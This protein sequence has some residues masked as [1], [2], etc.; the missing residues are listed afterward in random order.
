MLLTKVVD[1]AFLDRE[2]RQASRPTFSTPPI[3]NKVGFK[4]SWDMPI[5]P[6]ESAYAAAE[7]CVVGFRAK[8]TKRRGTQKLD[9]YDALLPVVVANGWLGDMTCDF[10]AQTSG[11]EGLILRHLPLQNARAVAIV[12]LLAQ[13]H[14]AAWSYEACSCALQQV[15]GITSGGDAD[16]VVGVGAVQHRMTMKFSIVHM[17]T[18]NDTFLFPSLLP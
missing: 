18:K 4:T 16:H 7:L 12:P 11:R 2:W 10:L 1:W 8:T 3:G 17:S 14:A 5:L 9:T 15:G 13:F 6:L